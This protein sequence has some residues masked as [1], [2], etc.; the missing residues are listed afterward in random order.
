M[1]ARAQRAQLQLEQLDCGAALLQAL[2]PHPPPPHL[3]LLNRVGLELQPPRGILQRNFV[4]LQGAAARE[5]AT[6]AAI[7]MKN[8]LPPPGKTLR[9]VCR[10][11]HAQHVDAA[12][13]VEKR[14]LAALF[15]H[16]RATRLAEDYVVPRCRKL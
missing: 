14:A 4:V 3:P 6:R 9:R 12:A 16:N 13:L 8:L 10:D 1:W 7:P 15:M 5:T 2:P 11:P